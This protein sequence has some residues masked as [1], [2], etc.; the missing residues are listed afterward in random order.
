MDVDEPI[1]EGNTNSGDQQD[2]P[3]PDDDAEAADDVAKDAEAAADE[4]PRRR[5]GRPP[6]GRG[7]GRGRGR[8][9]ARGRDDGSGAARVAAPRGRPKR[10][11]VKA[12]SLGDF[13]VGCRVAVFWRKEQEWFFGSV[14]DQQGDG[15]LVM[16]KVAYDDG[17]V[18]VLDLFA[19]S[20]KVRLIAHASGAPASDADEPLDAG[21]AEEREEEEPEDPEAPLE[22]ERSRLRDRRSF[23]R[24]GAND[25][26]PE[27]RRGPGR[28]RGAGGRGG[29]TLVAPRGEQGGLASGARARGPAR[30]L[31]ARRGG[32]R[33]PAQ[34]RARGGDARDGHGRRQL[35]LRRAPARGGVPGDGREGAGGACDDAEQRNRARARRAPRGPRA[36]RRGVPSRVQDGR[37]ARAS[38]RGGGD[39]RGGGEGARAET[40]GRQ[41]GSRERAPRRRRGASR[42]GPRGGGVAGARAAPAQGD[43]ESRRAQ[44]G[45]AGEAGHRARG[46]PSGASAE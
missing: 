39:R 36:Q 19:A 33:A 41:R 14:A 27:K 44:E 21:S 46:C 9:P 1:A 43:G 18:E 6:G 25:G 13:A 23:P 29:G 40:R 35:R 28:P 26:R 15:G 5:P 2:A 4:K 24:T 20:A 8:H 3:S 38:V 17:D 37:T 7:R 16:S 34:P 12:R 31:G 32:A 30:P 45:A 10:S 11:R 22:T 42:R